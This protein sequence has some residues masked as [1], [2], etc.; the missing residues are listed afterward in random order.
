MELARAFAAGAVVYGHLVGESLH[1]K[2]LSMWAGPMPTPLLSP[3]LKFIW[4]PQQFFAQVTQ[5][6]HFT[7]IGVALFFLITGWLTPDMMNRG[8]RW[9]YLGNRF[10]RIY[11]ALIGTTLLCA[12][13]QYAMSANIVL[14]ATNILGTMTTIYREVDLTPINAVVWTLAIEVRFYLLSFVVG[15][16]TPTRLLV[17]ILGLLGL[18]GLGWLFGWL[19]LSHDISFILFILVGMSIRLW[20][21][22]KVRF[23]LWLIILALMAF[24]FVYW[25]HGHYHPIQLLSI[26]S[27][28]VSLSLL[29]GFLCCSR[30]IGDWVKTIAAPTYSLYL[31]H[32]MIGFPVLALA[33]PLTGDLAALGLALMSC[34]L[35]SVLSHR[36]FEKPFYRSLKRQSA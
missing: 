5:G 16:W 31:L 15:N 2:D 19:S 21:K 22:D 12:L 10:F 36:Y 9:E 11:P 4:W 13:I 28:V 17:A 14:S 30:W 27:Q 26:P 35:G 32:C 7:V 33:R 1:S 29:L 25:L 34:V 24:N 6:S 20:V 3:S 23:N 18:F 8:S